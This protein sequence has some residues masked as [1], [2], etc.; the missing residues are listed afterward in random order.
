MD[1]QKL[2]LDSIRQLDLGIIAHLFDTEL[3]RLVKDCE[4][5]PMLEKARQL[6]V[7]FSLTPE[8]DKNAMNPSC[9]SVEVI[10][11]IH[12]TV[13]KQV[14]TAYRM[15]P[16]KSGKDMTLM[17]RPCDPQDPSSDQLYDEDVRQREREA[18]NRAQ[19]PPPE[20]QK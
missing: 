11:Q 1:M 14:T 9:G 8:V 6:A 20:P 15:L 17:F 18:K 10:A 7:V 19:Q 4:D 16:K 2:S 5:R 3:S 12:S 13:P